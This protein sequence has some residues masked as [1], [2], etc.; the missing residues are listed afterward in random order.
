M[1][2]LSGALGRFKAVGKVAMGLVVSLILILQVMTVWVVYTRLHQE[3]TIRDQN[4]NPLSYRLFFYQ[5]PHRALDAAL[6][7]LQEHAKK[8]AILAGS[9][10]H[11]V[12]LRTGLQTVM[13]PISDG[14]LQ[15]AGST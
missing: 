6:D 3:G 2:E 13:S 15:S 8:P 14:S 10:P 5:E 1:L 12:Y 11:W 4:G 9:M 7:W